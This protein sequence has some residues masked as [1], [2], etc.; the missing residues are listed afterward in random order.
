LTSEKLYKSAPEWPQVDK[1][2]PRWRKWCNQIKQ[3]VSFAKCDTIEITDEELTELSKIVLPTEP[4]AMQWLWDNPALP[5]LTVR[6][7]PATPTQKVTQ[8]VCFKRTILPLEAIGNR[9]PEGDYEV[10]FVLD[11]HICCDPNGGDAVDWIVSI[12]STDQEHENDGWIQLL[13]WSAWKREGL[14]ELPGDIVAGFCYIYA[15][16]QYLLRNRPVVFTQTPT[17]RTVEVKEPRKSGGEK[18]K[19]LDKRRSVRA[20]QLIRIKPNGLEGLL[21]EGGKVKRQF[22]CPAWGVIGHPRTLKS[23]KKIQVKP[24]R[25]G[26]ERNNPNVYVAKDYKLSDESSDERP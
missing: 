26:R 19:K 7:L 15:V 4:G 6:I 21:K 1:N 5:E 11:A 17:G 8:A 10:N 13:T 18:H 22:E 20:V 16:I 9:C 12:G 25:K 14:R 23:G 24:H 2:D 3:P